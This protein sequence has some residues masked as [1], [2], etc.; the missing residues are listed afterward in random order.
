MRVRNLLAISD[1]EFLARSI[2][3]MER[4]FDALARDPDSESK[5][6]AFWFWLDHCSSFARHLKE[7]GGS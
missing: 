7:R 1:A 6:L 4:A 5:R 3:T 2:A